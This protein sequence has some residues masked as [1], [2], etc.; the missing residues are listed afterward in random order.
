[1]LDTTVVNKT[2]ISSLALISSTFLIY[3]LI[4]NRIRKYEKVAKISKLLI[5]PVKSLTGVE[6][7]FLTIDGV[8]NYGK[9]RDRL[10]QIMFLFFTNKFL[11]NIFLSYIKSKDN[12][13]LSIATIIL[14]L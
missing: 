10:L 5:Y 7:N 2:L 8:P 6:V 13:C 1:M 14:L 12:S 9:Y 3:Y 4:K 11:K